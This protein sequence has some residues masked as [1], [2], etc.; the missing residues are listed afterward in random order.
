M[1]S[2]AMHRVV[3]LSGNEVDEERTD[4]VWWIIPLVVIAFDVAILA[5]FVIAKRRHRGDGSRRRGGLGSV[6][7]AGGAAAF[8]A[9][10]ADSGFSDAG[11]GGHGGCGGGSSCGG[12][13][14][15]GGGC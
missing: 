1:G 7:G 14:C 3:R 10:G 9:A 12:G 2:V 8:W 15:G 4:I 11:H 6:A 13:G 5:I